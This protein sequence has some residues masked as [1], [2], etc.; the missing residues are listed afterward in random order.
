MSEGNRDEPPDPSKRKFLSGLVGAGAA[1]L[2]VATYRDKIREI[3]HQLSL[4]PEQKIAINKFNKTPK[5]ILEKEL[6]RN[7]R[8]RLDIGKE[9]AILRE[10]PTA[11]SVGKGENLESGRLPQ[12]TPIPEALIVEGSNPMSSNPKD[13]DSWLFIPERNEK[14]QVTGGLFVWIG[15]TEEIPQVTKNTP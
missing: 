2:G 3:L 11:K 14:Q 10:V 5:E 15:N 1:I 13:R 9:G 4:T 7:R 8:V 6:V 12:G